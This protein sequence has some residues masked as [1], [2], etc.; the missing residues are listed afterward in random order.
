[1]LLAFAGVRDSSDAL[2]SAV[3]V[4]EVDTSIDLTSPPVLAPTDGE[5]VLEAEPTATP[6]IAEPTA[7]PTVEAVSQPQAVERSIV[8]VQ[9]NDSAGSGFL[10]AD[11]RVVTNAHVIGDALSATVWFSNGA[12][13]ESRL[14]AIDEVLD[15]AI[16]EVPRA[17]LSAEPLRLTAEDNTSTAGSAVWAWGY[18]FEADVVAAG[19]SRA[20]TVSRGI[21]SARRVRND[22]AYIQTDAAVNPGS[23]GG[24]LLNA[25]GRVVGVN[26]LVLTPNGEDAE[27]LNFALDVGVHREAIEQL[28]ETRAL[29]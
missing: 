9:T 24:P 17:P 2:A 25:S 22:V 4:I 1:M 3:H 16:L 26:T 15:I 20:P 6:D 7:T 8:H 5:L 27:G 23:S 18:P 29:D 13:R 11:S 19:F 21:V 14:V 28:L 10:V 12:R